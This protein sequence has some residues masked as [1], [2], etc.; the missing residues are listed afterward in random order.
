MTITATLIWAGI[1]AVIWGVAAWYVA[2]I[3]DHKPQTLDI[4]M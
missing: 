3:F 4:S 2:S 1:L